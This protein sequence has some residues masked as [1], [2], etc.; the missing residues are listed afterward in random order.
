MSEHGYKC[1][2]TC[3]HVLCKNRRAFIITHYIEMQFDFIDKKLEV[4][5]GR[6]EE[7]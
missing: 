3:M 7:R 1:A 6:E 2:G 4:K 5:R